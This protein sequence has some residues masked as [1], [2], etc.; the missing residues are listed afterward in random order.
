MT[1]SPAHIV[2]S[3]QT[4]DGDFQH[5]VQLS[6]RE[7]GHRIPVKHWTRLKDGVSVQL[8]DDNRIV[9]VGG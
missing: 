9:G 7:G 1:R 3:M 2:S 4:R 8:D 5:I 6:K